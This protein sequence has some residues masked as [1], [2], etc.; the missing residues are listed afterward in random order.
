MTLSRAIWIE[1]S[2]RGRRGMTG[3]AP[4]RASLVAVWAVFASAVFAASASGQVL[5]RQYDSA[6]TG[7]TLHET[8]LTPANVNVGAFG[9]QFTLTVDG[10]V[11]A[12]PL[13]V[14]RV[15][16][17]GKG[18][19]DVLYVATEHDSVYA[20][21]AAGQPA[22]PLWQVS[23]LN[24]GEGVTTVSAS[25]TRCPFIAPEV[26]ITPTPVIDRQT[27]TIYVLARTRESQGVLR[28]SNYVQKLHAL[29][30]TTG[31]EKFGGPAVIQADGFDPL[32]ELPRAALLLAN[33]QV[34]L[35]WASSC[36][37][38]PYH[39]YVMAY[40]AGTLK[41][42]AVFNTSP[43][44]GLS[45]IWQGDN[46]PA[47]DASGHVYVV[48]GNGKFTLDQQGH[49]YGDSALK[50]RLSGT[51]LTV[52]DYFT[53]ANQELLNN[54]DRDLGSGGVV[55]LP[56]SAGSSAMPHLLIIGGKDGVV[57]VLNRDRLR[58]SVHNV[59][60]AGGIYASP[61]YWNGHLFFLASNDVVRDYT[62]ANGSLSA[63]PVARSATPLGNPGA[64]PAISAN[65]TRDGI[66]WLLETKVWNDYGSGKASVLHAYEAANV[67]HEI[68]NSEQ[69]AARDRAGVTVRFTIPTIANGRVY[70]PTKR[71]ITVYGPLAGASGR[72]GDQL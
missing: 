11:Y 3:L 26:G 2:E 13:Y 39:G 23:F 4:A 47:V 67:A 65:G 45:G 29:A 27:G 52:A 51:Q 7:A 40:D 43:V 60:L 8:T 37:I 58:P 38:G 9:K 49:D 31:V 48:T 70:V 59:K 35:T 62:I 42:T 44:A 30:I 61:A 71:E 63:E 16:V 53:P 50:L 6:R 68:Y 55:V 69:N 56:D 32:R 57:C 10:D 36:D 18:T 46:G 24:A 17:P 54:T 14:P 19:H 1:P 12:Q 5:T 72:P 33:G 20:F 22:A 66:V 64:T 25:D 34:Y 41:Q 21:D 28:G 15:E